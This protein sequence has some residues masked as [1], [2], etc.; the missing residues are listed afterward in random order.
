MPAGLFLSFDGLDGTGKSTQCRR[1]ATALKAAGVPV[2]P[3]ADPGGTALGARL[4]ELLLFGREHA[5]ATRAEALLFMASRAQL[6]E[7]VIRPALLRGEVVLCDRYLL[8]NVVYQGH[9][10]GLDPDD[11][12]RVGAFGTGGLE[13]ARTLLFDLPVEAAVRRGKRDADRLESRGL[14]YMQRVRTGFLAEAARRPDRITV[15]DA[16]PPE[17]VVADRVWAAVEPLLTARRR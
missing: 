6:V 11:L 1:L 16:D 14:D 5:L 7:E 10:G 3:C 8:A 17:D 15:I 9:A 12:W 13:P 2:T 4:R